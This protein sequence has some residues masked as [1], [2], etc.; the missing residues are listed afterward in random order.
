MV[1]HYRV[2]S[3][4]RRCMVKQSVSVRPRALSVLRLHYYNIVQ[5][6]S[7]GGG[8]GRGV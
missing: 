5:A 1:D 6:R 8:G 2:P 7:Q 3:L 4:G